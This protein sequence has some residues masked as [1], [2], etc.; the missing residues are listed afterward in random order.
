MHAVLASVPLDGDGDAIQQIAAMHGRILDA[1]Q[2]EIDAAAKAVSAAVSHPLLERAR[3]AGKAGHCRR[4]APLLWRDSDG[5]L[6]E[7][8]VDLAFE[9]AGVWTVIDF[10]TDEEIAA[11]ETAY[12]RQLELYGRGIQAATAAPA[13]LV[14]LRV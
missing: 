4:E 14:L 11:N 10:K 13:K 5:S 7:G 3:R 1:A 8:V 2:E 12:R 6:V 9:E